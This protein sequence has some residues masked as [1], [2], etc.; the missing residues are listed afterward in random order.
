MAIENLSQIQSVETDLF[1]DYGLNGVSPYGDEQVLQKKTGYQSKL[2]VKRYAIGTDQVYTLPLKSVIEQCKVT[3]DE[4]NTFV[5]DLE[6]LLE[7][8]NLSPDSSPDLQETHR[9]VWD[10]I[11]SAQ[12]EKPTDTSIPNFINYNEFLYAENHLCRGCRKFVKEYNSLISTTTFGHLYDFRKI[13]LA[14]MNETLCIQRSLN[15]DFGDS[16]EDESQQ[17]VAS[18]YLYWLKMASHYKGIFEKSI[19]ASPVLLPESEVDQVTQ[20][21][22]AQFQTFFSIRVNSETT[23]INNQIQNLS[24]DLI[25]DCNIFYEKF[26]SPALKFKTKVGGDLALDFRTTNMVGQMPRLAEEAVTAVLAIEGNFKALLTDLLERRNIMT[27]KVDSLYQSIIQRRKYV[28]YIS[29]LASK[30]ISKNKIVTSE[31][32]QKY[33]DIIRNTVSDRSS[34]TE[35]LK[36]SHSFLDDLGQDSHPQ[37]LLKEGGNITGNITIDQDITIDGVDLSSHAHSGYDGSARIRSIDIDYSTVRDDYKT[38]GIQ[39]RDIF[40]ISI[41]SYVPDILTGGIP[42]TDVVVSISIPD[43]LVDKYNFEILYMEIM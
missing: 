37:Y 12:N 18:Y 39:A 8:V 42:V 15:T 22:A 14:L 23:S 24:K 6:R 40:D 36:S 13:I 33:V 10:E 3:Y 1:G 26:L 2:D 28:L 16:Y 43:D 25:E 9:H 31:F 35:S 34:M 38:N 20:R 17:Q 7:Q 4:L 32:D 11:Y 5:N 30:A 27:K 19:P 41:D 21:Q 29:Q